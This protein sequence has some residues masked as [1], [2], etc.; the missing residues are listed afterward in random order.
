MFTELLE[1]RTL[2]ASH[3]LNVT[4]FDNPDFTGKTVEQTSTQVNF[5]WN[6]N[7]AP[8]KGINPGTFS[9]RLDG[10]V[11]PTH[12]QTYTFSVRNNDGV[13]LWVNGKLLIDH[14]K[15]GTRA[16]RSGSIAL[17][18][19]HLYDVRLEYF[20]GTRSAAL[21]LKWSSPSTTLQY[22]PTRNL[23]AYDTRFAGIGDFGRD[24]AY[25]QGTAKIVNSWAP[26]YIVTAGDNDY[27]GS[28]DD[29]V[30][31][32]YHQYIGDYQGKYGAGA[33]VNRFFPALGNHDWDHSSRY[34][35]FFTLPGNE[36]YYDFVEGKIHFFVLDSDPHEPDGTSADS[37]QGQWLQSTMSQS[38]SLYNVVIFHHAPYS[39]GKHANVG[40]M[41]WPFKDWGADVV[42]SGHD[43][44]YERL[45]E[46]GLLY[47]V[48][49][50][51]AGP[52]SLGSPRSGSK[53]MDN[54]DS[55]ALLIQANDQIMTFQYELR[56]GKVIDSY[57]ITP[58]TANPAPK[59]A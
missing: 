50:S 12:S 24:T 10:L 37:V 8:V 16:T 26:N 15:A 45:I 32:F 53:F 48:N 7:S 46:D 23:F 33:N 58:N 40:Y 44:D 1:R 49:G 25:S 30:G 4:Y 6:A 51:G 52:R 41:R 20:E 54:S 31:Q 36:R 29:N 3:G 59:T 28:L 55:G 19:K 47:F 17:K 13:R 14:W 35:D 34:L 18:A 39:S 38:T 27:T 5:K 11:Q 43:H 22:I 9:V 56:S 57:S 2:L 21:G 42:I